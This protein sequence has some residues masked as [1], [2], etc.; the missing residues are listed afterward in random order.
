MA[1]NYRKMWRILAERRMKKKD[2]AK[3]ANI[4]GYAISKLTKNES[5]TVETL[6]KI[7]EGLNCTM[8]EIIE[9]VP[10]KE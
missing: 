2:L 5:V 4:S 9:I 8:D 3:V 10:D 7:C 1:V 6:L